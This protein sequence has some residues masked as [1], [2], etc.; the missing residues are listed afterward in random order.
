M[1][2]VFCDS[3][4]ELIRNGNFYD[5]DAFTPTCSFSS[6]TSDTGISGRG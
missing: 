6:M 4:R 2:T 3:N 1:N 5:N